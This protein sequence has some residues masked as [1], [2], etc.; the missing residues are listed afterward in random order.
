MHMYTVTQLYTHS[1]T[2]S[3]THTQTMEVLQ[4]GEELVFLYQLVEGKTD[5]SYACH[6]AAMMGLAP[7]LV[8]RGAKVQKYMQPHHF[9]FC[10]ETKWEDPRKKTRYC[11]LLQ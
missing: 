1:L 8:Q 5:T 10:F 4:D 3:L 7:E 2:H 11:M 6:I 9:S